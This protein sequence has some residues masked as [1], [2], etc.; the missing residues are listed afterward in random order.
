MQ[1]MQM[2]FFVFLPSILLSGFMFPREA[3][4]L[5]FNLLGNILPLT[6]YLQIMRSIIL[7]GVGFSIVWPQV[8]S[9][10]IYIMIALVIS[11]KKFQK[12]VA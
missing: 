6:F 12:K 11:I 2:S 4:P 5:F 10:T 3:M 9:L 7:K 8:L 1:A